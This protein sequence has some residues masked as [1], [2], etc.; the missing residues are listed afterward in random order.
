MSAMERFGR[1]RDDQLLDVS[2]YMRD[3]HPDAASAV[4]AEMGRRRAPAPGSHTEPGT[5]HG[6]RCDRVHPHCRARH[7]RAPPRRLQL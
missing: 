5:R 7:L 3:L 1:M 6:G 2:R 4:V